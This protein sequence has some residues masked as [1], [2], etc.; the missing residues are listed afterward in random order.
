MPAPW[1]PVSQPHDAAIASL[2]HSHTS[3]IYEHFF[4]FSIDDVDG[5]VGEAAAL[6]RCHWTD[7]V[8]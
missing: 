4:A 1:L 5:R 7:N 8:K 6:F 2:I 3:L